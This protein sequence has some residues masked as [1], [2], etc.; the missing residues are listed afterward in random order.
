[1][2]APARILASPS[3]SGHP[4]LGYTV[5]QNILRTTGTEYTVEDRV[6]DFARATPERVA[7][8][9]VTGS[10]TYSELDD[11]ADRAATQLAELGV[12]PGSQVAWLGR[13]DFGYVI[14]LVAVRRRG[15]CLAGLNWREP[16]AELARACALVQP[17]VIVADPEL[18][19]VAAQLKEHASAVIVTD[20]LSSAPWAGD[21]VGRSANLA[22]RP[23]AE[24]MLYFTSGST[25]RPKAVVHTYDC[26]NHAAIACILPGFEPGAITLI[27]PPAFHL[28]G[29]MWVAQ[30]LLAG[31]TMAFLGD[32]E[33]ILETI[34]R[35]GV[36][37][38]LM[39]PAL[40]LAML[41]EQEVSGLAVPSLG[42]IA[43]GTSPIAPS[44]L[45]AA[46]AVFGCSFQ[47]IYGSTEAGGGIT[48]LTWAEHQ[49]SATAP[50]RGQ[51]AGRPLPGIE[52]RIG[53][54]A[55]SA[56]CE[57][58]K[59]GEIL[60][61]TPYLMSRY[62]R[63]PVATA[64]TV[65]QDGWLHTHDLGIVDAE[66]Y[67]YVAGRVDDVI[68][69]GGENV[70]PAEVEDV[71]IS[72]PSVRDA[73]VVGVPDVRWGQAVSAMVVRTADDA[74]ADEMMA[75][76]K[77]HLAGYKCPRHIIFVDDLPR[78]ATGKVVRQRVRDQMTQAL[79]QDSVNEA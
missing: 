63:D 38:A 66:G 49:P 4:A 9:G 46:I 40:I 44:L 77:E 42:L 65:D 20:R 55:S 76:C 48:E 35:V 15:A 51:S 16:P 13:N 70:N 74:A 67:V 60:V 41:D 59:L 39:V 27:I 19:G 6:R 79:D 52:V 47:Q 54:I 8:I 33:T 26:V 43:Y 68:I 56:E 72:S 36:T 24:C 75:F 18:A 17:V 30:S 61:R 57:P 73:A 22:G 21:K 23:G 1:M 29:A 5:T 53:D 28:A 12:G 31:A 62:W 78:N 58:S 32:G 14:T 71:L 7:V 2:R 11:A 37:H 45:R 64:A 25:G 69:T 50:D 10:M 34:A 3:G